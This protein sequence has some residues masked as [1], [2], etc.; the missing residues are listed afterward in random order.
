MVGF[1]EKVRR[2][3]ASASSNRARP[4]D[5][6]TVAFGVNGALNCRA[7]AVARDPAELD[8]ELREFFPRYASN[9]FDVVCAWY[10]AV[11]VDASA[12]NVFAA[13]EGA[14]DPSLYDFAVSPGHYIHLDEW[15]HSPF[16]AGSTIRLCSGMVLQMDIIPVSNG[17]FCYIN[18]EDGIVLADRDLRAELA[19]RYPALWRRIQQRQD[20]M[21]DELGIRLDDSVLPLSNMPGWLPP[22]VLRPE[23][24]LVRGQNA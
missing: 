9:Y 19:A 4:G 6:F 11:R 15:V 3:L 18:A 2:G 17:P 7:G 1:G 10:E 5:A 24:V 8:G 22:Y 16:S 13:A 21:R 14:R 23:Q 20:F 12:G